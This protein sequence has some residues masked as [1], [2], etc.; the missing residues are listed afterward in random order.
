MIKAELQKGQY[1]D[2]G[3]QYFLTFSYDSKEDAD[4]VYFI[5][6]NSLLPYYGINS[7]RS[8]EERKDFLMPFFVGKDGD[9][10]TD[11]T[12]IVGGTS[13]PEELLPDFIKRFVELDGMTVVYGDS[14]IKGNFD[15]SRFTSMI[16]GAKLKVK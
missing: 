1:F 5:F 7:Y 8:M 6:E 3:E 4:R 11:N 12:G 13:I 2:F 9:F 10:T 15:S 16:S 14:E